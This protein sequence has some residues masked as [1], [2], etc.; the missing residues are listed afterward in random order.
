MA[1]TQPL[2]RGRFFS[3]PP[4][5]FLL[6]AIAA[7]ALLWKLGAASLAAWD[8]AIYAQVSKEAVRGGDWL[9]LHWG[10]Q[11]WFE[12]PPLFI[13]V[14]AFFYRLF[15]VSEFWA[16]APSALS[17]VALIG[18][19][20]LI[21]KF[22]YG[23]RV[24]LL[25]AVILSTCYHFL[26]F[27]RFGTTDVMLTLFTYLAVYGYVRLD[28]GNQKW[29]YAVWSS[30]ALAVMV[31]G[32]GGLIAPAAIITAQLFEGR[33]GA[34][35]RSSHFRR[36]VLL[37]LL[38]IAPWHVLM[39]ARHGRA[40][41]DEYVGYHVVARSTRTLEGHASGYL[42]Y[43]GKLADGFFPWCL[44]APFAVISIVRRNR[45][46]RAR[47][48]VLLLLGALVLGLYTV[49]PTRRPWYIVPLYPAL[50]ILIAVFISNLYQDYRPSPFR[51]RAVTV[52]CSVLI[53]A[54]GLYSFASLYFN[55]KSAE[56]VASLSRLARST[57]PDDQDSLLLHSGVEPIYAQIPLFYSDRPV[58]Q[59]YASSEPA[60]EDARRYVHYENL[61][62]VVRGSAERII[63][64]R[65]DAE[66]LAADYEIHALAEDDSLVY[67]TIS[68][69]R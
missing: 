67:A 5:I 3:S 37:A 6:V 9:T 49:V 32:A 46:G 69:R 31:K 13:W 15:G 40:F 57:S 66:R 4:P 17:G 55:H 1:P 20:Y 33:F 56:P 54:G 16:R 25:A 63:L 19:T 26:S 44:L 53:I 10:Y 7:F 65:E 36:G 43:V 50:A 18:V 21:G 39:Y 30:C 62:E 59:T 11:P 52:A 42:Y 64:R 68:R 23:E 14:T 58:R 60:G 8:E 41:I 29:W 2:G 27:S 47:P 12:K 48:A 38:I 35:I 34:A 24:G 22:I 45:G 61:A 28:D 51:R